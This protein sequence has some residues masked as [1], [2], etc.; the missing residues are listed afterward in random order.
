M[1]NRD[2]GPAVDPQQRREFGA[3]IASEAF[4]LIHYSFIRAFRV[5]RGRRVD[6]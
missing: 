3:G 5:E 2:L 1:P 4:P 6:V